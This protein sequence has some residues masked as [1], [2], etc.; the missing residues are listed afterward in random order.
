MRNWLG[1]SALTSVLA[2]APACAPSCVE[3]PERRPNVVLLVAD[4]MDYEHFG[5][6]GHPLAETPTLDALAEQGVLFTHGFVPM[7][8]CRPAQAALLTG[9]WPHQN[10]VYFNVGADHI[11][12]ETSLA[13]LLQRAGYATVGEGK[14]WEPDPRAMGFSNLAIA[15]YTTFVRW[16]QQ[17]LFDWLERTPR[18]TPFFVWWAPELPHVPHD[19]PR[20]LL[21]RV[22]LE[23]IPIPAWFA[24]DE[25]ARAEFRARERVLLAM[26]AWLDRGVAELREKLNALGEL[27]ETLFVFL[28][29][30]GWANGC[31]SKGWGY[32]KGLRTPMIVSWPAELARGTRF[33]DLVSPVDLYAT[34]L[35]YAGAPIPA[36][37]EG[38]SLRPRIEGRPFEPRAALYGALYPL[39]PTAE[40]ADPARDAY[41]LWARTARWKFILSLKDIHAAADAGSDVDEREDIKV[42]LAPDFVRKRGDIEL[43]DLAN[44]PYER[45]NLAAE[46]EHAAQLAELKRATLEWWHTTG[47]GSLEAP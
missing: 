47:G 45:T 33:D 23:S 29:D 4:D 9:L 39:T 27:E 22:P 20:E 32:D 46:P 34:I 5:F 31:V 18:A 8:R 37:S 3:E 44:D 16:D 21:E 40:L 38:Q 1:I 14:F 43:Y 10:G 15:N 11:D 41:A 13:R 19:P 7:S 6:A 2:L 12:P 36:H 24:G 28:S 26:D 25:A 17:H 30:N 42:S 35:D